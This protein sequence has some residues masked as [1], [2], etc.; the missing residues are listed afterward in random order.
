MASFDLA[1]SIAALYSDGTSRVLEPTGGKPIR[2][3]GFSVGAPLLTENAPH[4]GE[5]HPD[6]DE[7]LYLVSGSIDVIVEDG[8]TQEEVGRETVLRLE[9]GQ[10]CLVPKGAWHRVDVREPSHLV[11]VTPGPGDGHRPLG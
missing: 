6:G 2:V 10:A 7:L 3:D 8:G 1:A 5:M 9:A 4:R 11:H